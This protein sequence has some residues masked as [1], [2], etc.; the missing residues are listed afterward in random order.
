MVEDAKNCFDCGGTF[1]GVLN[2]NMAPSNGLTSKYGICQKC[3]V[4]ERE[5][6]CTSC[7]EKVIFKMAFFRPVCSKCQT[8]MAP[9]LDSTQLK[10]PLTKEELL[11][12]AEK[13][14]TIIVTTS[15]SFEGKKIVSYKGIVLGSSIA[16]GRNP[17][18]DINSKSIL[19]S[20]VELAVDDILA[21][22]MQIYLEN[23]TKEAE[24]QI[25]VSA[26][27]LGANA[28]IAIDIDFVGSKIMQVHMNGTAVV[29]E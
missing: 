24:R 23:A 29:I 26:I 13:L 5:W 19:G 22:G 14:K 27:K 7:G 3:V 17:T 6:L 1:N 20:I 15:D 28:V 16:R 4:R 9:A 11:E 21:T 10:T 2:M 25:K 8:K 12:Q 18:D